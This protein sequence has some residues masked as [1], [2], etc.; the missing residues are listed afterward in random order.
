[1]TESHVGTSVLVGC[2]SYFTGCHVMKT[3]GDG[4]MAIAWG[5]SVKKGLRHP[6]TKLHLKTRH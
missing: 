3:Q 2:S 5:N 6:W 4:K 1:M